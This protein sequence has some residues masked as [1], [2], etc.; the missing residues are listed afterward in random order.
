MFAQNNKQT[1]KIEVFDNSPIC[2]KDEEKIAFYEKILI[3][4][5]EQSAKIDSLWQKRFEQKKRLSPTG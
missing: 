2:T 5:I 1:S 4:S 3:K